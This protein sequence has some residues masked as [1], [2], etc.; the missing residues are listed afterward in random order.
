ML[1]RLGTIGNIYSILG[2][3]A[4]LQFTA[5]YVCISYLNP[6]T[7]GLEYK[8]ILLLK[9]HARH[10]YRVS[11]LHPPGHTLTSEVLRRSTNEATP[12]E[13]I[14]LLHVSYVC[15]TTHYSTKNH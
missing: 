11:N 8:I 2:T 5:S 4:T 13:C 12:Y 9:H 6:H 3:F 7:G 15:E 1:A 14:I 10:I